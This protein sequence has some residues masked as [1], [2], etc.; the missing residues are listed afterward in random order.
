MALEE[1]GLEMAGVRISFGKKL[2]TPEQKFIKEFDA[3]LLVEMTKAS[4][5]EK[6][7]K[8]AKAQ[9]L[10]GMDSF[11]MLHKAHGPYASLSAIRMLK[12]VSVT[13]TNQWYQELLGIKE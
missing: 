12:H 9:G 1:M 11:Q 2:K 7:W 10:T 8:E 6:A 13:W 3:W 5:G 4:A